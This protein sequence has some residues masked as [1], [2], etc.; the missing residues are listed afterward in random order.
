MAGR[1]SPKHKEVWDA[2]YGRVSEAAAHPRHQSM[3][4]L[5]TVGSDGRKLLE[6]SGRYD[7]MEAAKVLYYLL[8]ELTQLMGQIAK[9]TCGAGQD[10]STNTM[11]VIEELASAYRRS[12][13][14]SSDH[15]RGYTEHPE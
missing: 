7:E 4:G 2:D 14:W 6:M 12:E 13:E 11:P 3:L 5:I 8:R 10:W 15:V 1:V 9:L